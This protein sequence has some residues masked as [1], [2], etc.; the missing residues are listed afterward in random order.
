[1]KR[2]TCDSFPE[3]HEKLLF[4][5]AL[6]G[7]GAGLINCLGD[8]KA[9][10]SSISL[11]QMK[12]EMRMCHR[13]YSSQILLLFLLFSLPESILLEKNWNIKRATQQSISR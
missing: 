11:L 2:Q 8:W 1:M 10:L 12:C 5:L 7:W 3:K 6:S 13:D 4:V 9:T